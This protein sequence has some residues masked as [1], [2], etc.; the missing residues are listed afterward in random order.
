MS[1]SSAT[2]HQ[3]RLAQETSPYLLQHQHNP[4]DWW[5]WGPAA[6]AE[7]KSSNKPILLSIGYSACH[8]CHVMAHE[9]FED[10]PT[11]ALL[12]DRFVSVKVDREERP[13]VDAVYME[14]VQAITGRGG[15]PMTVFLTPDRRPFYGGTYF[16]KEP[17]QGMPGFVQLLQAVAEAWNERRHEVNDQAGRLTQA[18]GQVAELA[19]SDQT[20]DRAVLD[21]AVA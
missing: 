3:N 14:A 11:A 10:E 17:R 8:W 16:P 13:D 19:P 9:S 12:N 15:W 4:V 5:A 18:L 21:T 7:A 2:S 1:S 20:V 6:L